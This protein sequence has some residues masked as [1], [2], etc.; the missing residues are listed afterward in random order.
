MINI[1]PIEKI[2]S[3]IKSNHI[4]KMN[5]GRKYLRSGLFSFRSRGGNTIYKINIRNPVN[6]KF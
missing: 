6:S 5:N 4:W 3:W 1:I 2:S